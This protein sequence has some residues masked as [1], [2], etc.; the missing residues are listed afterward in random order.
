MAPLPVLVLTLAV[1]RALQGADVLSRENREGL[2][3]AVPR[4]TASLSLLS[5]VYVCATAPWR[6][7]SFPW[8]SQQE[9]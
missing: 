9:G 6:F 5:Q 3:A 4:V 1:L 2:R 8:A 7:S